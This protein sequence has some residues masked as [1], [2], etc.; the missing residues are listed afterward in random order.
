MIENSLSTRGYAIVD[1]KNLEHL[2]QIQEIIKSCFPCLP[3]EFHKEST[4]DKQRLLF[5]KKAR[6]RIIKN[7]LVK[8]LFIDNSEFLIKL[9]G[10]DIDIQSE[11]YLRVSRPNLESDFID[12]HRDTFYGNSYWELV[13]WFPVFPLE[14]NAGLMVV[15][16]SHLEAACNVHEINDKNSFRNKIKK[17]SLANELG[18]LYAPKSDDTISKLD[19]TQVNLITPKL[20]QGII[21][22][23]HIVHR[24]CNS[25]P[26]TRVSLDLKIKNMF[27][28]T[29][30]RTKYFKPLFRSSV[31]NCVE[32]MIMMNSKNSE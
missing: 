21:F 10:P 5:V 29:N 15:E 7:E 11:V 13:C 12:W 28:P 22:F 32:K 1:F 4:D 26:L 16:G 20:G 6:D 8:K 24:A 18:Y 9:L 3:T 27:A 31:T 2:Y 19:P 17:G 14:N 30:T 25:S 23:T